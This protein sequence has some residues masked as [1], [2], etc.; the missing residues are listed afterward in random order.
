[1][2]FQYSLHLGLLPN[3]QIM[4]KFL[5][6]IVL[7]VLTFPIYAQQPSPTSSV[8][9]FQQIQKLNFLGSVLYIAAHPDDENTRM[10]AH[11]AN[12]RKARTGYLSL[13]RGDGG[14]N[15]IG[16]QLGDLLGVIRTQELLEARK[17]DG[18]QQFFT[19]ANDFG[20]S[21]TPD[22]TLNI[23]NKDQVLSDVVYVI[24]KFR[25][26]IIINRFDARTPGTTHGH[27]TSSAM[28]SKEAFDITNNPKIYSD[29][30]SLVN[31]W[32]PQRL[33]FNTSFWFYGG[34]DQFNKADKSSLSKVETGSF[35]PLTGQSNQEIAAL[36]RSRHQSQGFG[37]SGARGEDLD[38]LEFIKGTALNNKNDIFEGIDT[39]WNRVQG[40]KKIGEILKDVESTFDFKNPSASIP[41][42]LTAYNLIQNLKDEHWKNVKTDEIKD[43]IA[44]CSG[45]FL[46]AVA[47]N[48]TATPGEAVKV[49]LEAINR[50]ASPIVLENISIP[51]VNKSVTQNISLNNN[52]ANELA[53]DITL[54][55]NLDYTEPYWLKNQPTIGMYSV[56]D[57]NLIGTPDIV[58]PLKV[59]FDLK[60]DSTIIPFT[61]DVIYKFNDRVLG[62][63]YKP[64]DIIPSVTLNVIDD[65]Q[66]FPNNNPK[67]ILVSVKALRDNVAGTV[68]LQ[69]PKNWKVAPKS[70]PFK[71][72]LKNETSIHE[73]IVTPPKNAEEISAK[74]VA[75]I[76]GKKFDKQQI[77]IDYPHIA[78]QQVLKSAEAKLIKLD[79]TTG[80]ERVG[81]IMGAG[82]VVNQSL[83]QMGYNVK[84][85]EP[86]EISKQKLAEFD[87]IITGVRAYNVVK[88]LTT[89][90]QL[91]FDFVAEGKTM[92]V[93]YNTMGD[94]VL[95]NIAPFPLEISRDRVTEEDAEV[96]FLVP[97]HKVLNYPNKISASDFKN[98]KQEQGL[99]YPDSWDSAFTPILSS[100]DR[101]EKPKQGALLIAKYGKGHYI[102]TGL[103]FFRELPQGVPG[104]FRLMANMISISN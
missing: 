68:E 55:Q 84:I 93:Q 77:L 2:I 89:K 15:L 76:D 57:Q 90:Q 7:S 85:L 101:D 38:Y 102:Y 3:N 67:K 39:S 17:I 9:I 30:L 40:G 23:W 34:K 12:E 47:P 24:R 13:T 62:E 82:D 88:E 81:Y 66:I 70:F 71:S 10:I 16:P 56:K 94:I 32:Q 83:M 104:A 63:V 35:Y 4:H 20:Y 64:F 46:E 96:T 8:E 31:T 75:I 69:L 72:A 65:V 43:V 54:P 79:I 60:Y 33:F 52:K 95:K 22:E 49:K 25:P 86:S 41:S 103:S 5:C 19:R 26:D 37:T 53:I 18:G 48:Q 36:S 50:S 80:S 61:R 14:Q 99:Y 28:L 78:T 42:L 29:Q 97:N 58:R 51:L 59:Q 92:I 91:L 6:T 74:I 11:L 21:K 44:A 98:W 73:F 100:H 1:M 27:H 45:I 87:V